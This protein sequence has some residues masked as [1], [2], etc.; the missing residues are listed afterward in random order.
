MDAA[1]NGA[2]N[3]ASQNE[4]SPTSSYET[5]WSYDDDDDDDEEMGTQSLKHSKTQKKSFGRFEMVRN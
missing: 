5:E 3:D 1:N 2:F 4:T